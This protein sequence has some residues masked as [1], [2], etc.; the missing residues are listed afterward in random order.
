MPTR[1]GS[2]GS[3]VEVYD[4]APVN[5]SVH[6]GPGLIS[7]DTLHPRHP[8]H[9]VPEGGVGRVLIYKTYK[10]Y[11]TYMM[12]ATILSGFAVSPVIAGRALPP[13]FS[14]ISSNFAA[15]LSTTPDAA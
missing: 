8:A 9:P 13:G 1:G 14:F 4:P 11:R 5:R 10:D 6:Y 2:E 3:D 7:L 12:L 15:Q